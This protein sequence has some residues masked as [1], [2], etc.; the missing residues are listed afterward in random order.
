MS[1]RSVV[2]LACLAVCAFG[3]LLAAQQSTFFSL[4]Q[5]VVYTEGI[6]RLS[7]SRSD[8]WRASFAAATAAFVCGLLF[9]YGGPRTRTITSV[10]LL[11]FGL[12]YLL[13][14]LP[15]DQTRRGITMYCPSQAWHSDATTIRLRLDVTF[16]AARGLGLALL[17]LGG[18]TLLGEFFSFLGRATDTTEACRKCGYDLR[19]NVSGTCPECGSIVGPRSDIAGR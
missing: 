9:S 18:V 14:L 16:L 17:V 15:E 5:S 12:T 19:A 10:L 11:L 6:T 2:F 8:S 13:I 4:D 1:H 3:V 7:F